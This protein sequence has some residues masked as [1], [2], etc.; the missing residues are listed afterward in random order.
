MIGASAW[1]MDFQWGL[2]GPNVAGE[3]NMTSGAVNMIYNPDGS[4][5]N[6]SGIPRALLLIVR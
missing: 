3:S 6:A 2:T 1:K 4:F 5:T